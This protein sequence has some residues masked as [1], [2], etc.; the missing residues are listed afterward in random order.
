MAERM[1]IRPGIT[2]RIDVLPKQFEVNTLAGTAV[3]S[4]VKEDLE[5]IYTPPA[6]GAAKAYHWVWEIESNFLRGTVSDH[7]PRIAVHYGAT[8]FGGH[9]IT[10]EDALDG[11]EMLVADWVA[12]NP[13][14]AERALSERRGVIHV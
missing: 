4:R 6:P 2:A 3:L 14:L 5:S 7:S 12:K 10:V 8:T 9:W 13:D 11:L 1:S